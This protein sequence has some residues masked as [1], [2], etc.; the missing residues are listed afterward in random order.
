MLSID[1]AILNFIYDNLHSPWLN[2]LMPV[3][4]NIGQFLWFPLAAILLISKKYRKAG[5]ALCAA[6]LI[7]LILCNL[8]LKPA[9]ARIRPYD[10][11]TAIQ[12]LIPTPTDFSFP[13]GHTSL[14]FSAASAL[15][16]SRKKLWIPAFVI[17]LLVAFS[18]LYLYVHYPTDVLAGMLL[19]IACGFAGNKIANH[20]IAAKIKS[21]V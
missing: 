14:S 12:L 10:V 16:F 21:S 17:A 4:T 15:F 2:A 5:L 13:S 18:R 6:I 19:G 7:N 9:V 1:T 8:I 11:N 20:I 3:I